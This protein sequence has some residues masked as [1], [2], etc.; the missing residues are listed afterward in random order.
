MV[1]NIG[2]AEC[3]ICRDKKAV[4]MSETHKPSNEEEKKRIEKAGMKVIKGRINC[5]IA[6][7][8]SFGDKDFKSVSQKNQDE[9]PI[10]CVP[11]I[12]RTTLTDNDTFI[13][14][15][16]GKKTKKKKIIFYKF[17]FYKFFFI[18]FF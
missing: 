1:S 8:R 16:C 17:I 13:V 9:Q 11:S 15:C 18:H 4:K 7:S 2:D 5:V 6:V 14:L 3:F 12:S 10:S